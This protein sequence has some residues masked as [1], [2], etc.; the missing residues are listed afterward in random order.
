M[1]MMMMMNSMISS[2]LMLVL[3]QKKKVLNELNFGVRH[4]REV[5]LSPKSQIG[6]FQMMRLHFHRYMI[7]LG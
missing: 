1:M 2:M 5:K 6:T 7:I 3:T 4:Q